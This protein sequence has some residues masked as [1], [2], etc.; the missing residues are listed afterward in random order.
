MKVL[1][2]ASS[3]LVCLVGLRADQ[4][5]DMASANQPAQKIGADDLINVTVYDSPELTRTVRVGEE[6]EIRLPMLKRA[7]PAA[8]RMPRELEAAIADALRAEQI[9]VD[10][11]VSVNVVEY[12]SRPVSVAGAVKH[13]VTFQATG[14][15]TLLD[16]L[17]RADGLD[18]EAG[19][20]ILLTH[21]TADGKT[22]TDHVAVRELFAGDHPELNPHLVGGEEI[23][24]PQAARVYAVGNL[25]NP[26]AFALKDEKETS[27]LK[28]L[29]LAGGLAPF[30]CKEAYIYRARSG[31]KEKE[32]IPVELNRIIA[33]KSSDVALVAD[34]IFYVPDAKGRRLTATA[35]E[36]IVGFGAA[37]TSGLL[38]WR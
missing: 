23:R 13:P 7:I 27:V 8:G 24:V 5:A 18:P 12:R 28:V 15:V 20:E 10:P 31:A 6:G 34:D 35:L 32:E 2:A 14:N 38:I 9:L 36:K 21:T 30:A 19:S 22:V 3:V 33:R 4:G 37:T 17:T 11:V 16:A 26:G 25:K 29:A 1:L